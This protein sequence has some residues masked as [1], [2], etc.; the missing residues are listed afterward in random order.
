MYKVFINDK[1]ILFQRPSAQGKKVA[2]TA[3]NVQLK[4][5]VAAIRASKKG[6]EKNYVIYCDRPF[7]TRHQF[8]MNFRKIGAAG[9][10]VSKN[11][12]GDPILMIHRLGKWD[13]PKGKTEVGERLESA[14][15]RE[16]EEECSINK[17]KIVRKLPPTFHLYILKK[18]WV[19]KK[20]TWYFMTSKY[21]GVLIPQRE[22]SIDK[23]KWVKLNQL[24]K[25]LPLSYVSIAHLISEEF[26]G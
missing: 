14:A 9:G 12:S 22:E 13:L 5:L 8:L 18:E 16:V 10:L 23:V 4:D 3:L 25:Y 26:L 1:T 7:H 21:K 2:V 17:L 6:I 24:K 20:T 15:I 11:S 19:I